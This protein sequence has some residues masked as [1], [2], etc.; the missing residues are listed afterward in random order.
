MEK[1]I[2][3]P[4]VKRAVLRILIK[5]VFGDKG[6]DDKEVREELRKLG[7]RPL[8]KHREFSN[9][10]KAWNARM[11]KEEYNQRVKVENVNSSTKRKYEDF[12]RNK[13]MVEPVQGSVV[14]SH[15]LQHRQKNIFCLWFSTKQKIHK[16]YCLY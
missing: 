15:S 10:H 6:H 13:K 8:I 1:K 7:I 9:I 16:N 5:I 14:I 12:V 2:I 11:S 4:L 3:L